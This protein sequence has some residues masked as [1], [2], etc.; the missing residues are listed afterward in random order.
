MFNYLI[1]IEYNGTNFVGWQYQKNGMSI[2]EKIEKALKKTLKS[3]IRIIG[4]G[5]TDK[6]VHAFGQFANFIILNKIEQKNK[7]INS[8]NFFLN[9]SLISILSIKSKKM[10]FHSRYSAKERIYE[11]RIINREGSLSL[12]KNKAWHIKKKL[13]IKLLKKGAKILEGKH[14]FST[15]RSSSCSAKSPIKRMNSVTVK[16]K[17][18]EILIIFKSRSFLQNQVRSMVGCLKYLSILN[19]DIKKFIKVFKS[20]KRSY[21][22]PPAPASGLYLKKVIY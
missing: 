3:K 16:K 2:Q 20:K 4:A 19:W 7:F 8:V 11:Y 1:E 15:F 18:N 5:R 9:K 22:A 10:E 13:D 6:G 12:D 17:G 14:D 21:C